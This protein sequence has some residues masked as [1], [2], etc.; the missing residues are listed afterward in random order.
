MPVGP[1]RVPEA[2]IVTVGRPAPGRGRQGVPLKVELR[3]L[4]GWKRS[5]DV[6]VPAE[7]VGRHFDELIQD[8]RRRMA[9]PGFRKGHA[10]ES[11][12]RQSL[13]GSI[14]EELLRRVVP[15]AYESAVHERG[16]SPISQA[17]IE[18]L[19]Y[20]QGE[21]LRFSAV[22]EVR[23]ELAPRDYRGLE[24]RQEIYDVADEDVEKVLADLRNRATEFPIVEGGAGPASILVVDYEAHGEDG[25]L[26]PDGRRKD[27]KSVV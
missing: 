17:Q 9:V 27:R 23:P 10:P 20:K 3:E 5:L 15:E 4:E 11:V 7:E 13:G 25:K 22:F 1:D 16:L 26:L 24:F 21:P 19:R 14:E 6:E 8:Y 12:V 18:N 2:R